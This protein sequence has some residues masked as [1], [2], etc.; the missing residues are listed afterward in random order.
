MYKKLKAGKFKND[1]FFNLFFL[2]QL[3]TNFAAGVT[4]VIIPV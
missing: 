4:G 3:A 1:F 2:R